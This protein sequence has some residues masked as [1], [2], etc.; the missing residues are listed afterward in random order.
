MFFYI[1][2][3]FMLKEVCNIQSKVIL[4]C[5]ATKMKITRKEAFEYLELN[6]CVQPYTG[7]DTLFEL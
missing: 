4:S 6:V 2:F 3:L 5:F 1:V 7:L